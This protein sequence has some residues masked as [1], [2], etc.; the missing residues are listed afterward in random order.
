MRRLSIA[1]I[2]AAA[3]TIAFSQ[4]ASAADLG[5]P[6]APPAPV[7]NWSG[8]YVGGFVGG[9]FSEQN[10]TATDSDGF[11][12][13]STPWNYK[14]GHSFIGGGTIGWNWQAPGLPLL[15]GIEGEIGYMRLTGSAADPVNSNTVSSARVG[16]WYSVLA[17]RLGWLATPDWLLYAKGGAVWTDLHA[18]VIDSTFPLDATGSRTT[19]GGWALGGGA[20]WMF[21]PQ[22]SVKAEYIF[23]GIDD[24]VEACDAAAGFCWNHDFHGVHTVKVGLNYHF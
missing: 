18:E 12:A 1:V 13:D 16:D 22:W 5:R 20:E 3:S 14:L 10:V 23:L 15:W 8:I 11:N 9:A 17:F 7:L 2:A 19:Q 6:V 21:A 24:S 4:I